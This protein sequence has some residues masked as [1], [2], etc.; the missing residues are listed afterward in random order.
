MLFSAISLL[1]ALLIGFAAHRA[2]LCNVRAVAEI[3]STGSAHMLWAP[4]RS[5]L[6]SAGLKMLMG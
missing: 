4:A 6:E 3:M 2:S 1:C 5:C